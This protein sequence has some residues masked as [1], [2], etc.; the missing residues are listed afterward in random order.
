MLRLQIDIV[1]TILFHVTKT[2]EHSRRFG[3][4]VQHEDMAG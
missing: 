4:K 3:M 2:V 1:S